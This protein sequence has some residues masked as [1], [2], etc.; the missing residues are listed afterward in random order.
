[1]L[2]WVRIGQVRLGGVILQF[3]QLFTQEELSCTAYFSM[4]N[5]IYCQTVYGMWQ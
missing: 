3:V 5:T 1:M 4:Q 2:E